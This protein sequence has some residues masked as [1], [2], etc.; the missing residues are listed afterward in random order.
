MSVQV[1]EFVLDENPYPGIPEPFR[2][3][4]NWLKRNG[5]LPDPT[6]IIARQMFFVG[7]RVRHRAEEL[8]RSSIKPTG[9]DAIYLAGH[10]GTVRG[11]VEYREKIMLLVHWDGTPILERRTQLRLGFYWCSV[12]RVDIIV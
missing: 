6:Y 3:K 7:Q 10:E 9:M 1:G 2:H 5:I 11:F 4:K 8:G 12:E